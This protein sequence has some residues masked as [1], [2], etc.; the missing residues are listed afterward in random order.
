M[1]IESFLLASSINAVFSQRLVRLLCMQCRVPHV[2][3]ASERKLLGTPDGAPVT[4]FEAAG[5]AACKHTGYDNRKG[6][7]ECVRVDAG[8]RAL[9]H[10]AAGE[11]ALLREARKQGD[12][13]QQDGIRCVLEGETSLAEVLRVSAA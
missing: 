13:L 11:E 9:I 2:P 8:M 12:S 1:G 4:I 10:A 3:D 6:I 5:C 7:F